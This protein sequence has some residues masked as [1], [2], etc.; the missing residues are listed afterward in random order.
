EPVAA[1]GVGNGRLGLRL[2]LILRLRTVVAFTRLAML[3]RFTMLAR[4]LLVALVGLVVAI[5]LIVVAVTVT[6]I[7]VAHVRL[8]LRGDE[9]RLLAE[10]RK[11]LVFVLMIV[12]RDDLVLARLRLVLAELLLRRRDQAKV[13]LGVLIVV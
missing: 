12:S 6:L 8:R 7:V 11:A 9:T 10:A 5:T 4:L 1:A 13:M 3:A 2:G